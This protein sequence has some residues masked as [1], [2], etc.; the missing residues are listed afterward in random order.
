MFNII[1]SDITALQLIEGICWLSWM[2]VFICIMILFI[3][4]D[5]RE[6]ER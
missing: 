5:M 2:F 3:I 4:M 1:L 6:N